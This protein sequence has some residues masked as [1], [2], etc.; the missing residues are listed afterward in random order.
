MSRNEKAVLT[1]IISRYLNNS[2]IQRTNSHFSLV[3][4]NISQPIANFKDLFRLI[5]IPNNLPNCGIIAINFATK[6]S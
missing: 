5:E 4:T 1:I 3:F 2:R 6:Y